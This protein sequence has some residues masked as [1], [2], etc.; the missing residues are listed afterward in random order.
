MSFNGCLRI[1]IVV[2]IA[3]YLLGFRFRLKTN[4]Y[5]TLLGMLAVVLSFVWLFTTGTALL[6]G[7]FDDLF[8]GGDT[9]F[10]R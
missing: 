10:W 3:L 5:L 2:Y 7:L 4:S 8:P 6:D 1:F 9:E